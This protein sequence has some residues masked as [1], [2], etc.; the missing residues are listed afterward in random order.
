MLTNLAFWSWNNKI[1]K[2]EI[3][4][5]IGMFA[6]VG[7]EGFFIH[8]R[9]GLKTEYMSEKWLSLVE[10]AVNCAEKKGLA[11]FLYDENGWPSGFANG[12]VVKTDAD[13]A[14]KWLAESE[15]YDPDKTVACYKKQGDRYILT[16]QADEADYFLNY[17]CDCH[18]VDLMNPETTERFLGCVHERYKARLKGYFGK[19]IKGFFTDEP[20]LAAGKVPYSFV[21]AEEWNKR[22]GGG[23]Y[24]NLWKLFRTVEND[25]FLLRYRELAGELFV[26]SYTKKVGEWGRA[27]G[28]IFTGHMAA[29]D[30]LRQQIVS[31]M[32]V[33]PHYE[34]FTMPGI[35]YLGRRFPSVVLLKQVQSVAR[36]FGK[37]QVLSETF[38]CTGWNTSLQQLLQI[39]SYQVINGVNVACA[40]LAAYSIEGCRKRD[41]PE[42]FS[43]QNNAFESMGALFS[44]MKRLAEECA[45]AQADVGIVNALGGVMATNDEGRQSRISTQY[46]LLLENLAF[47]DYDVLDETL[48]ATYGRAEG[49]TLRLKEGRYRT[50]IV[51]PMQNMRATTKE[52]LLAFKRGGGKLIFVNEYPVLSDGK[53][54][55]FEEFTDCDVI[56][57]RFALWNKYFYRLSDE[58]ELTA[59][60]GVDRLAGVYVRKPAH[61]KLAAYSTADDERR[62]IVRFAGMGTVYALDLQTGEYAPLPTK[63]QGM[64]S[65]AE[66]RLLPKLC[67]IFAFEEG[68]PDEREEDETVL[69]LPFGAGERTGDNVLTVDYAQACCGDRVSEKM[70]VIGLHDYLQ[71][72]CTNMCG[73]TEIAV[74]YEFTVAEKPAS[75]RLAAETRSAKRVSVNGCAV[76]PDGGRFL[77]KSIVTY[78]VTEAV[79]EGVNTVEIVY[80]AETQPQSEGVEEVYETK[81]NVF[82]YKTEPESVYLLGDFGVYAQ[83]PMPNPTYLCVKNGDFVIGKPQAAERGK[84]V[85]S[86]N[87]FYVGDIVYRVPFDYDGVQNAAAQLDFAGMAAQLTVNGKQFDFTVAPFR[88]DITA[89]LR[90]G[91]NELIVKIICSNRNVFG[92]HHHFMGETVFTGAHTFQGVTGFEEFVNSEQRAVTYTP[93]Y[94]FVPY[95][96]KS[97]K[98]ILKGG[99]Q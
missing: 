15:C 20:Q 32:G 84:F 99:K 9:A 94:H 60:N 35:D 26:S 55:A 82:F 5:Q 88:R 36:Q 77:D 12:C 89:A 14:L 56:Q 78:S 87:Y 16:P 93:A 23:F 30:G 70:L 54:A 13:L 27:N 68:E 91:R 11:V 74:R 37:K 98:I 83:D 25:D 58:S 69:S 52:L 50:V 59:C 21:L 24:E 19:T 75:L 96:L 73:A 2:E 6:R 95:G 17:A 72:C 18:Y 61:N 79:R 86:G 10:Y 47:L 1:E 62:A 44:I 81:R 31:N 90:K 45:G 76:Q 92:P 38:G 40:H 22:Y 57:N 33:M 53:A 41:Y 64:Y 43:Y 66:V 67:C 48:L 39:W 34:H 65:Y 4:R 42:F 7:I 85:E 63:F 46:R 71:K 51:P 8:A 97:V 3:A 49:N 80:G 29:E 28:L